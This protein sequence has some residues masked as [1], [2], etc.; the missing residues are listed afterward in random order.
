[1]IPNPGWVRSRNDMRLYKT[2]IRHMQSPHLRSHS[3]EFHWTGSDYLRNSSGN[4]ATLGAIR[5][6]SPRGCRRT[7]RFFDLTGNIWQSELAQQRRRQ[8][9]LS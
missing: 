8:R 1:M 4:R 2:E 6:A 5:R 3:S 9:D 7:G